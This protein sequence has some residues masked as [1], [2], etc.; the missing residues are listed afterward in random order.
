[1]GGNGKR[2][3]LFFFC[4]YAVCII[5]AGNREAAGHCQAEGCRKLPSRGTPS[6]PIETPLPQTR[7]MG[8][9]LPHSQR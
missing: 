4:E 2:L 8:F 9:P 7:M 5:T 1:M 3:S 6:S